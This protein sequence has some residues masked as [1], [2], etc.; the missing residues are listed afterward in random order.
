MADGN[1]SFIRSAASPAQRPKETCP[2][3]ALPAAAGIRVRAPLGS[4]LACPAGCLLEPWPPSGM[5]L[6]GRE[7]G[8]RTCTCFGRRTRGRGRPGLACGWR[9]SGQVSLKGKV[10]GMS[11][12]GSRA[13]VGAERGSRVPQAWT[14]APPPGRGQKVASPLPTYPR[15][16]LYTRASD[17][18]RASCSPIPTAPLAAES[19]LEAADLGKCTHLP[20]FFFCETLYK[21][22]RPL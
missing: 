12:G 15:P 7:V 8:C 17:P 6:G 11:A 14:Q 9:G 21:N 20:F 10:R 16:V 3:F 13:R 19:G 1:C 22:S 2:R 4:Q 5:C 18:S